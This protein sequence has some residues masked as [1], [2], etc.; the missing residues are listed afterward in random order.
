MECVTLYVVFGFWKSEFILE[1]EPYVFME[2]YG[3]TI[4][5]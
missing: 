3:S 4:Q 5:N 2:E 1:K